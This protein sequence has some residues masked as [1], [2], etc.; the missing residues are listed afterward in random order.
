VRSSTSGHS[1][2]YSLS[3][4]VGVECPSASCTVLTLAPAW[5][6]SVA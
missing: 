2:T 5:I 3:V 4:T 6:S 1:C